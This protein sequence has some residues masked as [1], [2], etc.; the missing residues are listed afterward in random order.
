MEINESNKTKDFLS[1]GGETIELIRAKDWGK[2]TVGDPKDWPQSLRTM[3]SVM[4]DN[5]YGMY[6]AW[7]VV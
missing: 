4:L 2:T 6:I 7:G 3:V 5:P 1:G